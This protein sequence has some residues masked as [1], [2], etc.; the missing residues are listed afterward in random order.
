MVPHADADRPFACLARARAHSSPLSHGLT[1]SPPPRPPPPSSSP[2]SSLPPQRAEIDNQA[3]QAGIDVE[4]CHRFWDGFLPSTD[5]PV[6]PGPPTIAAWESLVR[7]LPPDPPHR[8]RPA[9]CRAF[10]LSASAAPVRSSPPPHVL[11][12]LPMLNLAVCACGLVFP[13]GLLCRIVC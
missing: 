9:Y 7:L 6:S 3:R 13:H 12:A 8:A 1:P 5:A 2:R 4:G 11:A 10:A